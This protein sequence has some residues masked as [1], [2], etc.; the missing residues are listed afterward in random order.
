[1]FW[2]PL[3]LLAALLSIVLYYPR[4]R[5]KSS[6]RLPPGPRGLPIV[7]S[8]FDLPPWGI[9]EY[10]HWLKLKDTY[11]PISSLTVFGTTLVILHSHEAAQEL[12]V[13]KSSKTSARPAF[14]FADMCGQG[15]LAPT[16]TSGPVHRQ[17]RKLMHQLMGTKLLVE[18]FSPIQDVE[19]KRLL[20]RV[21]NEPSRFIDHIKTEASAIILKIVYGYSIEPHKVDPLVSAI[22]RGMDVFSRTVL[23]FSWAVDIVPQLRHLPSWLPGVSFHKIA[24]QWVQFS[25]GMIDVPYNFAEQQISRG[26]FKP[27]Y[28]ARH[29]RQD[30]GKAGERKALNQEDEDIIKKSAAILFGGGA[31]TTVSS[32]SSLLLALILHPDVL[33]RAQK[34]IDEVVGS[35]RLPGFQDRDR[36]PYI[37]ALVKE[38]HRWMPVVPIGTTH[39]TEEE[40][41]YS[42]YRIPKGAFILPS[43]WWFMHDPEMYAN[44]S[45]F[46]PERFLEPRNEP[47]PKDHIFG[48]GRRI[49]PGRYLADDTMYLNI[50]RVIATFDVTRKLD[51][52]GRPLE[53]KREATA[54]LISRPAPF[55]YNITPRS[56]K[57]AALIQATE[58]DHPWEESDSVHLVG[59]EVE[60]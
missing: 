36:L 4:S 2:I 25:K 43:I 33:S 30:G 28:V 40:M 14:H 56:A 10:Q 59:L 13:K 31:D 19:S 21:M 42:G 18:Q 22:E 16:T 1:M 46:N 23:P 35:D 49:C 34:E 6:L 48:Y 58:K 7:G 54:G 5:S 32:L 17:H 39:T 38:T 57:H 45:E 20:L 37:N 55:P 44:P 27:S 8:V 15:G 26:T 47:D 51:E 11:G 12:L 9:P 24:R 41:I 50:S 3:T 52:Q 60:P 53:I 29:L